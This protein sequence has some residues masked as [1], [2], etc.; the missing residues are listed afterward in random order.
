MESDTDSSQS[1]AGETGE[2]WPDGPPSGEP[3][4]TGALGAW[5]VRDY[6][7]PDA[8]W[9]RRFFI[10]A[11]GFA[12]L[13]GM[14][15]GISALLGPTRSVRGGS[16]S[17][18]LA[19]YGKLGSGPGKGAGQPV[20][21]PVIRL[22]SPS[23]CRPASIV[24]SLFPSQARYSLGQR[25]QFAVYAVSTAR[26]ACEL[27]FGP[28][29]VRV[30]VTRGGHVVWSSAACGLGGTANAAGRVRFTR[31]VP[32]VATVSWNG[33]PGSAG[34]AGPARVEA[35]GTYAVMATA[36]GQSSPLRTFTVTR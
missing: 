29:V 36:D 13:C 22:D 28:A 35:A 33:Q 2:G 30:T 11:A 25:P 10:L 9:R 26:K 1:G 17:T 12:A 24:L 14:T 6:R 34:C 16:A 3:G 18:V 7:D 21:T 31:G 19:P 15:W 32:R 8:Y 20:Q 27:D 4:G 5:G 23:T